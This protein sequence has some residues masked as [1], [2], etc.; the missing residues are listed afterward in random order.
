MKRFMRFFSLFLALLLPGQSWAAVAFVQS[1]N[2]GS[3]TDPLTSASA[4]AV[5]AG[6]AIVGC[7][8]LGT[9]ARDIIGVTGAAGADTFTVL[10]N[11]TDTTGARGAM[12]YMLNVTGANPYTVSIDLSFTAGAVI[13]WHEV[14]GV[15]T[16]GALDKN[17]MNPQQAPGTGADAVVSTP[18]TTTAD[19]EYIFGCAA[20]PIGSASTWTQTSGWTARVNA[21]SSSRRYASGDQ[22]QS[23]AGSIEYK[24]TLSIDAQMVT[25]IVTLKAPAVG[26]E[27]GQFYKRWLQQ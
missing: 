21:I 24:G 13:I 11:P 2:N 25:G 14:S 12:F 16:A 6:N 10:N 8:W 9:V 4:G 17:A 20:D 19:G 5:T 7:V 23:S 27:T 26:G 15:A 18:V 22:I 1:V 3:S